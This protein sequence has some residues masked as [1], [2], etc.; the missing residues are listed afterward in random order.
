MLAWQDSGH[1]THSL[2]LSKRQKEQVEKAFESTHFGPY[3][4]GATGCDCLRTEGCAACHND[5]ILLD[6]DH[7]G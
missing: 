4:P 5:I 1:D 3:G 6:V 2:K 7:N